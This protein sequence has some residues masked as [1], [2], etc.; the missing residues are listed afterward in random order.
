MSALLGA[1]RFKVQQVARMKRSVIR[2]LSDTA[3]DF[4]ALHPGYG[5][6]HATAA[7]APDR[8]PPAP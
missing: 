4:A 2:D 8:I 7:F 5:R 6:S 3:P 1:L